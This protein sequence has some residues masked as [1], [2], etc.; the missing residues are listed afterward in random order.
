MAFEDQNGMS[1]ADIKAV[2]GN[3]NSG[4]GG[5]G[6]DGAWWLLVLFLFAFN[7]GWGNGFGGN[8]GTGAGGF[9]PVFGKP[10]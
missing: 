7:N 4:W 9:G 5:F 2:M 8:N 3:G 6:G 10:Y 1:P